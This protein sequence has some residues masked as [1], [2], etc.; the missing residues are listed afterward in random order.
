MN[1]VLAGWFD[2]VRTDLAVEAHD[3]LR[4]QA[5]ADIPGVRTESEVR[6]QTTIS[7]VFIETEEGSRRMG[8][9]PGRYITLDCPDLRDRNRTLQTEV[10][11][12]AATELRNLLQLRPQDQVLVVG[13]GNGQATPDALGP[14]IIDSLL[15]T[16]HL[17]PYVPEDL[18]GDLRGVAAIAPGV[19]GITGIETYEVVHGLVQHVRP[20][21]VICVDALA[22]RAVSRLCTSIQM[23]DSG[24]APGSGIGN[25]RQA[26]NRETLGV[27]VYAV[28]VP[29]VVHALTVASDAIDSLA[30]HGDLG[31]GHQWHGTPEQK[32][33]LLF[34]HIAADL[35]ELIVT[36]KEIDRMVND[37]AHLLA[38]ALNQALH[39]DM[40][41]EELAL[42]IF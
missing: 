11:S 35:G 36:P 17:R 3:L 10:A 20:D 32:R 39:P 8:R 12:L 24:I 19:L 38:E 27:P 9:L 31:I 7:R 1:D 5:Q 25:R 23:A 30:A 34:S 6:G 37:M 16:R 28:G 4:G 41:R 33:Q 2:N 14:R 29:T 21:V 13:L 40:T 22:A 26:L 15:V 18:R 42:H